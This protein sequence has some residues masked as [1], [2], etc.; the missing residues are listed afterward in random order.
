MKDPADNKNDKAPIRT[1][2]S[3]KVIRKKSRISLPCFEVSPHTERIINE[4]KRLIS[5][6]TKHEA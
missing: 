1:K 5:V 4:N 2:S 3:M 6:Y